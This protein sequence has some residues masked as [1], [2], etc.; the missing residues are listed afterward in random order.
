M[1]QLNYILKR[2][3]QMI[4]VLFA[5]TIIIFWGIRLIPGNPALTVLG[6]KASQSAIEAMEK[7]TGLDQPI[8][9]QYLFYLRDLAHLDF[10]N[11][12]RLNVSWQSRG[13]W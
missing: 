9:K 13:N 1:K 2:I 5:V 7:K 3:L 8:W 12:I 6:E 11:S 4:P 10:G